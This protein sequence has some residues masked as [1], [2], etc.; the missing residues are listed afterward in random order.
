[1]QRHKFAD[2]G[3]HGGILGDK[4]SVMELSEILNFENPVYAQTGSK[5]YA[6]K[7][8]LQEHISRCK[9][10]FL[11]LLDKE[12][13]R[14]S[15]DKIEPILTGDADRKYA[16]WFWQALCDVILFHDTGKINPVFQQ[17]AMKNKVW[18][19][20]SERRKDLTEGKETVKE[21]SQDPEQ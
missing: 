10:Y 5:V 17:K 9:K 1:M 15:F 4:V 14:D 21:E 18:M 11:R 6:E 16:D 20:A 13:M 2:F 7:E 3:K 12:K 19:L 8:T